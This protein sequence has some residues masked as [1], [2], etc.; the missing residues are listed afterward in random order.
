MEWFEKGGI[1][2]VEKG[3]GERFEKGVGDALN[4]ELDSIEMDRFRESVISLN[5][6]N[7]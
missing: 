2:A 1:E 4:L 6:H 5:T 3:V 7:A